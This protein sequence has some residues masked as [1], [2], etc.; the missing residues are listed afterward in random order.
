MS[1]EVT[2]E[3]NGVL[4]TVPKHENGGTKIMGGTKRAELNVTYNYSIFF[5]EHL[6]SEGLYYLC[7]KQARY[8]IPRLEQA[9]STLSDFQPDN[10]YWK[11]SPG[12][13]GLVINLLLAWAE[14]YPEATW[15]VV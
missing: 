13:A 8:T 7:G 2:L 10:D 5:Q 3:S 11:K 15:K 4:V 9:A 14:R 1:Y 12:N 6:G